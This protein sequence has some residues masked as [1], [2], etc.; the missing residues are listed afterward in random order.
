MATWRCALGAP[1]TPISLGRLRRG[2]QAEDPVET[3]SER[4]GIKKKNASKPRLATNAAVGEMFSHSDITGNKMITRP[5]SKPAPWA[6][7]LAKE[8]PRTDW[9]D[10][11]RSKTQLKV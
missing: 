2:G 6:S 7:R 1:S 5:P 11:Q 8:R 9:R 10:S 4:N 3:P